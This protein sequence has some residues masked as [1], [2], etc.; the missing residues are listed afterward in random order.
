MLVESGDHTLNTHDG[1][2]SLDIVGYD[3]QTH[4]R[5]DLLACT[6]QEVALIHPSLE[7]AKDVLDQR[8]A[9][10]EQLWAGLRSLFHFI[11]KVLI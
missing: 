3:T 6:E 10:L 9:L 7:C 4:L 11:P 5:F 8:F 2:H 1:E